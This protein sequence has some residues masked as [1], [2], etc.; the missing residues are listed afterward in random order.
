[1]KDLARNVLA[2]QI[3]SPVN[4]TTAK[5]STALDLQGFNAATIVFSLGLSGDTLATGLG[6][7]LGLQHSSDGTSYSAVGAADVLGGTATITVN[8][9]TADRQAYSIGYVGNLRYLQATMTP[10]GSPSSGIPAGIV[11]LRGAASYRP[12]VMP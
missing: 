3:L 4:T 10:I 1:M 9:P 2:T 6:W 11:A 5:T 8:A 12:V 7:T